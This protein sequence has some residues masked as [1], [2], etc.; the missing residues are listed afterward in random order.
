MG[1]DD[2]KNRSERWDVKQGHLLVCPAYELGQFARASR[3]W[4]A[5]ELKRLV[6]LVFE[7]HL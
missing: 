4:D 1:S 5:L 2:L 6:P 7:R 3:T